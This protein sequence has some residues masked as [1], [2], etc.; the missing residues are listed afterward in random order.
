MIFTKL[1]SKSGDFPAYSMFSITHMLILIFCAAGIAT[2]LWQ[3][4]K[5]NKADVLKTIRRC[6]IVMWGFEISKIIFN[7]CI[8]NASSPG[9]YIP[10]YFCSIPL[11]CGLFSGF[12]KDKIKHMGDVFL[13][14]GGITGGLGY[15]LSPC[16]TA[17]MYP[18]FHFIT[19]Q[20]F[21]HHS[22]MVY[23][24]ILLIVTDY[25]DLKLKDISSYAMTVT[26]VAVAA[27]VINAFL[28]T[29]LMFVSKTNPGTMV[30]VVYNMSPQLFPLMITFWQ[31]VPPFFIIYS[32]I[33]FYKKHKHE[34]E[35]CE[36]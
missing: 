6:V 4:R 1:F 8:G 23:L 18:A 36:A 14:V 15:M 16:T 26:I 19:I 5:M 28:D 29:N 12:G 31:A 32:L 9:H 7:L 35:F 20:S 24:S 17:G 22:I 10:L 13:V 11:Y 3:S 30:D 33:R 21:I 34:S 27:Y 25:I 2:A